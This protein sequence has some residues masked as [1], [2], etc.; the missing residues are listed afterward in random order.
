MRRIELCAESDE[1]P[2]MPELKIALAAE[3]PDAAVRVWGCLGNC[4]ECFQRPFALIDD[5]ELVRSDSAAG[6][7][8][9]IR[10]LRA[11]EDPSQDGRDAA[12]GPPADGPSA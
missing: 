11:Q 4:R 9:Q 10:A 5:V 7:L 3:F 12:P 2:G 6:L 8:E 1:H